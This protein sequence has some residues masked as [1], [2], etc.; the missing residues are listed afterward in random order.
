MEKKNKNI[1]RWIRC[2]LNSMRLDQCICEALSYDKQQQ[3]KIQK[4]LKLYD[5]L[6][7]I[8]SEYKALSFSWQDIARNILSDSQ[9]LLAR[10]S[11]NADNLRILEICIVTAFLLDDENLI[12]KVAIRL[13]N[14]Y[15]QSETHK[16]F[17]E[18]DYDGEDDTFLTATSLYLV[19]RFIL[20]RTCDNNETFIPTD[21]QYRHKNTCFIK[22]LQT[23]LFSLDRCDNAAFTKC[24]QTYLQC[25]VSREHD[26]MS[27]LYRHYSPSASILYLL[28]CK[29][30]NNFYELDKTKMKLKHFDLNKTFRMKTYNVY[31][32]DFILS[33]TL[34]STTRCSYQ[35]KNVY[36]NHS[37]A[38]KKSVI[39]PIEAETIDY[40]LEIV[41]DGG[42]L[43]IKPGLYDLSEILDIKKSVIIA[44]DSDDSNEVVLLNKKNS[45]MIIT[46]PQVI[47]RNLSIMTSYIY[48]DALIINQGDVIIV[49]CRISSNEKTGVLVTGNESQLQI[50][51]SV[52]HNCRDYGLKVHNMAKIIAHKCIIVSCACSFEL[53]DYSECHFYDTQFSGTIYLHHDT[54]AILTCCTITSSISVAKKSTASLVTCNIYLSQMGMIGAMDQSEILCS[55]CNIKSISKTLATVYATTSSLIT[56]QR[57][58]VSTLRKKYIC[59]EKEGQVNVSNVFSGVDQASESQVSEYL[60]VSNG[61]SSVD[62]RPENK[63]SEGKKEQKPD[64]RSRL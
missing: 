58:S 41:E 30:N 52:I 53:S 19:C 43:L 47:L 15:E 60:Y 64:D 27:Y 44:G 20:G 48:A 39:V 34:L 61:F 36:S 33:S 8:H 28:A 38:R 46:A 3:K 18:C 45:V 59:E 56:L 57:C 14:K 21:Y 5:L 55:E 16:L 29:M 2:G 62:Q 22:L 9:S 23:L 17:N 7:A 24:L 1:A 12:H 37:V 4:L 25:Y 11:F 35:A 51:D 26:G 40:A 31:V 63:E 10:I 42:I 13:V 54:K 50:Q 32:T 6:C 49:N